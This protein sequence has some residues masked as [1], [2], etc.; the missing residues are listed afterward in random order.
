[1]KLSDLVVGQQVVVQ[2]VWG[3]QKIEF[4]S[5]VKDKS[6]MN[7]IVTPY[8]HNNGPLELNIEPNS[9]VDCNVFAYSSE[10]NQRRA[11]KNVEL[12][13]INKNGE[14]VYS[15]TTNHYNHIS[16]HGDRRKHD[17]VQI[18][19]EAKVCAQNGVQQHD[20]TIYDISD[21]GISFYSDFEFEPD[22]SSVTIFFNDT[23]NN[24]EFKM[25][26]DCKIVRSHRA[27]DGLFWGCRIAGENRDFLVYSLLSRL[28]NKKNQ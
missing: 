14:M 11:W 3:E 24:R 12:H 26:V 8:L 18:N 10:T 15:I 2:V 27:S 16:T 19:K 6:D 21:I 5:Y 7:A 20:I 25:K 28:L 1:M 22:S 4:F 9:K 17:R 23:L 13:T